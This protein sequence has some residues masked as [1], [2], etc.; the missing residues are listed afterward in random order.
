MSSRVLL[1]FMANP[2]EVK[3]VEDCEIPGSGNE[4]SVAKLTMAENPSE[5]TG[6][7]QMLALHLNTFDVACEVYGLRL[8]T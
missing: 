7:D 2:R 3:D 8:P 5:K 4:G 1:L 6:I